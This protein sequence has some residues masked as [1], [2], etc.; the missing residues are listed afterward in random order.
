MIS[1]FSWFHLDL[2]SSNLVWVNWCLVIRKP[3]HDFLF[4]PNRSVYDRYRFS[5]CPCRCLGRV[6]VSAIVSVSALVFLL[7]F[8]SV[9]VL[10]AMSVSVTVS[11]FMSVTDFVFV[12]L[13]VTLSV[14]VVVPV[15]SSVRV[16]IRSRGRD[17][18]IFEHSIHKSFWYRPPLSKIHY[19]RAR[20]V[21]YYFRSQLRYVSRSK[22]VRF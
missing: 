18:Y 9:S 5:V 19:G 8:R 22:Q 6:R 16:C 14:S 21:L 3:I 7:M 12:T 15:T 17:H 2:W 20:T 11:E 13:S 10:V 1:T 4:D